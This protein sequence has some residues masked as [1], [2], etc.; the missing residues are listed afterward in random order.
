METD[1]PDRERGLYGKYHVEKVNGKPIGQCFVL[2]E[3]DRHAV[4]ALRAYA[5]SCAHDY[6][7]LA[8]DLALMA[9]RWDAG[10]DTPSQPITNG[11]HHALTDPLA[12]LRERETQFLAAANHRIEHIL[13]TAC[14][15][16]R[17]RLTPEE[18]TQFHDLHDTRRYHDAR[19]Q[20]I[21]TV[22]AILA[23]EQP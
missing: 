22:T 12:E 11:Q 15:A 21:D 10:E 3:H 16:G 5:E 20:A 2:E 6:Q 13:R 4:P 23:E 1:K 14:D 7:S 17:D 8:T 18:N 9:D 19:I